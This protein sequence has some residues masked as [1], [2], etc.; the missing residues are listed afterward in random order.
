M[1]ASSKKSFRAAAYFSGAALWLLACSTSDTIVA[2]NVQSSEHVGFVSK[3]HV[4][5]TQGSRTLE[6]DFTMVPT[7]E[8]MNEA[9]APPTVVISS[10]FYERIKLD[11]FSDGKAKVD[12]Q[13]FD[14]DGAPYLHPD[15]V[16]FEVRENGA[17]AVFVKLTATEDL[18]KGGSGG[19]GGAGGNGGNGGASGGT[20][21]AGGTTSGGTTASG[22]T[23]NVDGGVGGEGGN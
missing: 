5:F 11:S 19:N 12:V 14:K 9:G 18:P 10:A 16:E 2:L 20:T 1:T 13:S 17:T 22:G 21:A 6:K 4:T 8:I 23:G 3:L 7:R 15:P